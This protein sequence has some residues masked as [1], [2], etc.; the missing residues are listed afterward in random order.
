LPASLLSS[1][2][3]AGLLR[4][5]D[6]FS[7]RIVHDHRASAADRAQ[8]KSMG[9]VD[10]VGGGGGD[11]TSGSS[12]SSTRS[13]TS[14]STSTSTSSDAN[15]RR[16]GAAVGDDCLSLFLNPNISEAQWTD[17]QLRDIVMSLLIAG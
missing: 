11:K 14:T 1:L 7:E 9:V 8:T 2:V 3:S 13:S 12:T 4:E 5:L 15:V 17:K 6:A 10:G 16:L